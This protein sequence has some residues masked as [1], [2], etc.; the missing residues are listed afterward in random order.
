MRSSLH[1][2]QLHVRATSSSAACCWIMQGPAHHDNDKTKLL[3]ETVRAGVMG[4]AAGGHVNL[5]QLFY[6]AASSARIEIE[7]AGYRAI[8]SAAKA[9][10]LPAL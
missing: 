5:L 9:G 1:A 4:A 2:D 10:H 7:H 6:A 8:E 3:K